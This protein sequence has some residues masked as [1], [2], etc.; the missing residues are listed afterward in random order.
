MN[1]HQVAVQARKITAI[2]SSRD[3]FSDT[4]IFRLSNRP[5]SLKE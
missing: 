1:A 3:F 4:I 2:S 5:S